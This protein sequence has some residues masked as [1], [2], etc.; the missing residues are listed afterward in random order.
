MWH[1]AQKQPGNSNRENKLE[2][3]PA[4][5]SSVRI[6]LV[7]SHASSEDLGVVIDACVQYHRFFL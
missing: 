7:L 5:V 6:S 4:G 1:G 2:A 3:G